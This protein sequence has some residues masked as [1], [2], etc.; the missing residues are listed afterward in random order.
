MVFHLCSVCAKEGRQDY[1][2]HEWSE[3]CIHGTWFTREIDLAVS[4][5]YTILRVY[6]VRS[7]RIVKGLLAGDADL[8]LAS[9]A[10]EC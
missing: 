3:R 10:Q 7:F 1:C 4:M 9:G 2:P 6:E 8:E 5:G